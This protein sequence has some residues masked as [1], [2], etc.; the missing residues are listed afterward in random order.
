MGHPY[1]GRFSRTDF[2]RNKHNAARR[3]QIDRAI[4]ED[5]AC[6]ETFCQSY[7]KD[8][9][10]SEPSWWQSLFGISPCNDDLCPGRFVPDESEEVSPGVFKTLEEKG[11]EAIQKCQKV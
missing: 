1:T 5:E 2:I 9:C 3:Q 7:A 8:T 6:F 11:A 4:L 10:T